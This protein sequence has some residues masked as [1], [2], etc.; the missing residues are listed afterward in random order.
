MHGKVIRFN[1]TI[2]KFQAN[3]EKVTITLGVDANDISLD[4]LNDIAVGPVMAQFEASQTELLP[5]GDDE[6]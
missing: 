3:G 2:N 6:D 4:V 1:G 5:G